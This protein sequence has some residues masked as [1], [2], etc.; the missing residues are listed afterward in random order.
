MSSYE[1]MYIGRLGH[2]FKGLRVWYGMVFKIMLG[3]IG[4]KTLVEFCKAQE[5]QKE[6]NH[7]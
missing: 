3:W 5:N 6:G 7:L 2:D 1:L 4:I